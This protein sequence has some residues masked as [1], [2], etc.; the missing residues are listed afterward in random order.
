MSIATLSNINTP[1][2]EVADNL[3]DFLSKLAKHWSDDLNLFDEFDPKLVIDIVFRLK[4]LDLVF[5]KCLDLCNILSAC[6]CLGAGIAA[7]SLIGLECLD[8]KF[9]HYLVAAFRSLVSFLKMFNGIAR[10]LI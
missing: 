2:K 1:L 5:Y 7:A 9:L 4:P 10:E 8:Q 6:W 3:F